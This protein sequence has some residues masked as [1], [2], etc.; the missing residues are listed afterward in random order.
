MRLLKVGMFSLGLAGG[1]A[2][3]F[4]GKDCCCCGAGCN[5]AECHKEGWCS[6]CCEKYGKCDEKCGK[7]W[8][9]EECKKI[10][11]KRDTLIKKDKSPR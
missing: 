10:N 7:G 3:T 1:A 9:K 8:C 2:A 4:A 5:K 6:C 11:P